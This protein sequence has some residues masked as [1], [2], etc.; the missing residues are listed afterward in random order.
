MLELRP[1]SRDKGEK[2][3]IMFDWFKKLFRKKRKEIVLYAGPGVTR[4]EFTTPSIRELL[5]EKAVREAMIAKKN[6]ERE[7]ATMSHGLKSRNFRPRSGYEKRQ[8]DLSKKPEE[9]EE[10]D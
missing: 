8:W 7:K 3:K 4:A 9:D 1:N 2:V 5:R 10:R 6:Q